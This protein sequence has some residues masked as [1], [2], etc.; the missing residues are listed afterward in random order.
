[1]GCIGPD[2]KENVGKQRKRGPNQR[3]TDHFWVSYFHLFMFL[4][5]I[6]SADILISLHIWE[7]GRRWLF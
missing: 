7:K 2:R 4:S 5:L 3:E 1:M 6:Y